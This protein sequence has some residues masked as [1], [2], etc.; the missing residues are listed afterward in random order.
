MAFKALVINY[1]SWFVKIAEEIT[2]HALFH[3]TIYKLNYSHIFI[4][5]KIEIKKFYLFFIICPL[6][7]ISSLIY[8]AIYSNL[9]TTIKINYKKTQICILILEMFKNQW[10]YS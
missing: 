5:V 2:Q 6:L 4:G 7:I 1:Y 9:Q 8:W 3:A 10:I